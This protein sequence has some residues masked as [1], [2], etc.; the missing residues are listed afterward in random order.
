LQTQ[1]EY[2]RLPLR[3][4]SLWNS[5]SYAAGVRVAVEVLAVAMA[6]AMAAAETMRETE[7]T[8]TI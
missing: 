1:N 2:L 5:Q 4:A 7:H 8:M 3:E 6:I